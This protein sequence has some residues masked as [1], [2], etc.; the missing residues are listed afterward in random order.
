MTSV[1]MEP[2][3]SKMLKLAGAS[4]IVAIM[5]LVVSTY[6]AVLYSPGAFN[7]TQN[8]VSD[9]SGM[10]YQYFLN[11]PR[12]IVN[13]FTTEVLQRSGW[14]IGGALIIIFSLGLYYDEDTP[15]Y[16]LGA[17]FM[18]AAGVGC[19][20]GAM[21]PEPVALPHIVAAYLFFISAAMAMV[22]VGS[23]LFEGARKLYGLLVIIFGIVAFVAT[24][25][26]GY[27]RGI[28][29]LIWSVAGVFVLVF[30]FKMLRHSAYLTQPSAT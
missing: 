15:S 22:L 11:V 27:E 1:K 9:L 19:L 21:F 10:G 26:V 3:R 5:A 18:G 23:A 12:P 14:A 8:W 24:A 17:V 28:A 20:G 30:S 29:E 25:F 16:R 2:T 6:L 7:L 13:S 4:G